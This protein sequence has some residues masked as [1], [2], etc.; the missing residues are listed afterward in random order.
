MNPS[1]SESSPPVASGL[2]V[3]LGAKPARHFKAIWLVPLFGFLAVITS[4]TLIGWSPSPAPS[5]IPNAEQSSTTQPTITWSIGSIEVILSPGESTAKDITF[6]SSQ[7]LRNVV[8]E[9]VP[10]IAPFIALTPST[11]TAVPANTPQSVRV[12]F[13]IAQGA[14][15]GTYQ[16][17][18]HLRI[19]TQT[20]PQTM[21]VTINVWH[22]VS[23]NDHHFS[24]HYPP[25]MIVT[26]LSSEQL[27][28]GPAPIT[29]D[30]DQ[31][32]LINLLVVAADTSALIQ[33][34][35]GLMKST[36][37]QSAQA[38][39][40]EVGTRIIGTLNDDVFGYGGHTHGYV[41]VAHIGEAFQFDYDASDSI[42]SQIFE[43]MLTTV[44]FY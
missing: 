1:E 32:G 9:P 28:F 25:A 44:R 18:I 22:I 43:Q 20:L 21:K 27:A 11:F 31:K 39:D 40:G 41:V 33:Q 6:T 3:E 42:T 24:I 5:P 35:R 29:P 16:G 12:T 10:A 38:V 14:T 8:V 36:A 30:T 23:D 7:N 13:A 26:S 19:G 34:I 37:T 17:T 2:Q 4:V 15:L